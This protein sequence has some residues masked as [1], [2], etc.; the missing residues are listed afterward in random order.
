MVSVCPSRWCITRA[1]LDVFEQEVRLLYEAG[2]IPDDPAYPNKFHDSPHI[3]PSMYRVN[4]CYIKPRTLEAGTSWALMR[5]PDGLP[6]DVFVSHCWSEGVFEFVSKVRRLWPVGA[7]G[8]YCC[9]LSNPQNGDIG[10]MLGSN[11]MRSPFAR[12]LAAA[13]FVLVVPNCRKS[14]YSRLWCVFEAHLALK[15]GV[16]IRMPSSSRTSTM[17][18]ALG[19]GLLLFAAT[20]LTA[21]AIWPWI[22]P[23]FFFERSRH[24]LGIV[25]A[26]AIRA[27]WGRLPRTSSL[28]SLALLG[29]LA[30]MCLSGV[31]LG[32][33]RSLDLHLPPP[34][35]KPMTDT[36]IIVCVLVTDSVQHISNYLVNSA[37]QQEGQ[38][39]EF[40]TVRQ[41]TTTNPVDEQMIR[42]AIRGH[43]DAIDR[44]IQVLKVIGRYDK[45]VRF[46]LASGMD[47]QRAQQ[48]FQSCF[49]LGAFYLW[50]LP[51]LNP[52]HLVGPGW[53]TPTV[54]CFLIVTIL[55]LLLAGLNLS[56]ALSGK[57][58]D[59]DYAVVAVRV[60]FWFS[61][62]RHV[63]V[64][65]CDAFIPDGTWANAAMRDGGTINN[66]IWLGCFSAAWLSIA[67]FYWRH[68]RHL[69]APSEARRGFFLSSPT[70]SVPRASGRLFSSLDPRHSSDVSLASTEASS[71]GSDTSS[72]SGGSEE[73]SPRS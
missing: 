34:P 13:R 49:A 6:C 60:L 40:E 23:E 62:F 61:V 3:G 67:T 24:L 2:G 64:G 32:R 37:V 48:G 58:Y 46:N 21:S 5:H 39:M 50:L 28:C 36:A 25:V 26:V 44:S 38:E 68:R 4:E 19:P 33:R 17:C 11:P 12:A 1:D 59:R 69:P 51:Y 31:I 14:I 72:S 71:E 45:A 57:Y 30:G 20:L 35:I 27:F 70:S 18:R 29:A 47:M 52:L 9:F 54:S 66:S 42:D 55:G 63:L 41:A 8:L 16:I 15:R 65:V 10:A 43:E 53:L 73:G 22:R 56:L 7:R